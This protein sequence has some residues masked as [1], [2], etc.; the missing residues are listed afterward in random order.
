MNVQRIT[1]ALRHVSRL[2]E[3]ASCLRA[4]DTPLDIAAS[5]IGLTRLDLPRLVRFRNGL[6]YRLEEYY[7]LETLWQIHFHQVYPLRPTDVVI[8]DAGANVGL[9]SCWAASSNPHS[10]VFA[11][12]PSPRNLNRLRRH[13][14]DNRLGDR[15]TVL[16]VA[17]AA[18]VE[19]VWLSE[20]ASASQ[21]HHVVESA[22]AGTVSV[23][24]ITMSELWS[25]IP[26]PQIDFLKMDIEGSEYDVLLAA[27]PDDLA[28]VGHLSVEYHEP[29]AGSGYTKT[30]LIRHLG[31]CGFTRIVDR[32][33][34]AAF[35]MLHAERV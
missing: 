21:M 15:I 14:S 3:V 33:P 2:P 34:D 28:A 23:P 20:C 10:A 13:V 11:V 4:M 6:T 18:R 5:Y 32:H 24:A 22:G 9:F 17:L 35:G 16:P 30:H 19:A 25:R 7:D 29:P 12:E 1:H 31:R 26:F 8:V 27:G